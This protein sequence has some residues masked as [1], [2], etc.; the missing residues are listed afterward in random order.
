LLCE[1][2]GD[3]RAEGLALSQPL[4]RALCRLVNEDGSPRKGG[5]IPDRSPRHGCHCPGEAVH[6]CKPVSELDEWV[7]HSHLWPRHLELTQIG[8]SRQP[9][10]LQN[11]PRDIPE[12]GPRLYEPF[13]ILGRHARRHAAHGGYFRDVGYLAGHASK[14]G[15]PDLPILGPIDVSCHR[16]APLPQGPTVRRHQIRR[17]AGGARGV[18][19][20]LRMHRPECPCLP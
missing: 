6:S 18:Q 4:N 12:V 9:V 17:C 15:K 8:P 10:C 20:R 5:H 11:S 14:L 7:T 13:G 3:L 16:G 2:T 19:P 1:A